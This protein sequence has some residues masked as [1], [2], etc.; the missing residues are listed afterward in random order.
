MSVRWS[1][2]KG[3][4]WLRGMYQFRPQHVQL[5]GCTSVAVLG[6]ATAGQGLIEELAGFELLVSTSWIGRFVS[7][8]AP[9]IDHEIEWKVILGGHVLQWSKRVDAVNFAMETFIYWDREQEAL[10]FTQLTN[11]GVHAKGIIIIDDSVIAL[12]GY[13][14]QVGVKIGFRQTFRIMPDG[15]LEDRYYSWG[16]ASWVAE[17]VIVYEECTD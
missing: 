5:E 4:R 14:M 7:T 8:P 12:E 11:R 6:V 3:L 16:T 15:T 10:A 2:N 17:H 1:L 9:P 13:T